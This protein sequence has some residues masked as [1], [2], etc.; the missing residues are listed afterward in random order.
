MAQAELRHALVA[1]VIM[2]FVAFQSRAIRA[3]EIAVIDGRDIGER[4]V[5]ISG[6]ISAG[7][8]ERVEVAA[9][10]AILEGNGRLTF[11][12]NSEG[13]DIAEA[14]RIGRLARDLLATTNV[15]GN[16]LYISGTSVGKEL[17]EY[18]QKHQNMKFGLLAVNSSNLNQE[19]IV[20]CYSAC[21]IIF[22]G[23]V[24]RYI[25]DNVDFRGGFRNKKNIPVIGIHRPYF[26]Q[27]KYSAL[28]PAE[29]K[30]KYRQ[31]EVA[32]REYLLEMGATVV[33]ADRIF[34]KASNEMEFILADSFEVFYRSEEPFIE[35]WLIAKCGAYGRNSILS[36]EEQG[37]LER[38]EQSL[39][40]AIATGKILSSEDY[41][42]F[43]LPGIT[44]ES[45]KKI[46]EKLYLINAEVM[47]CRESA[48]VKHQAEW[49]I[50]KE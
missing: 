44:Q 25:S 19:D 8:F 45:I 34:Q 46:R 32:V 14:M 10:R 49:A 36:S 27:A 26:D 41:N 7:D 4:Y 16:T 40:Q 37:A 13:G 43:F 11:S 12:L 23:G 3:A 30:I 22:Y 6:P 33:L 42:E 21:V 31:L 28:S 47:K 20:R 24:T 50:S 39:K 9:K 2:M 18:G 35:E 38:Y 5:S 15:Y 29:A 1:V 48:I 17:E